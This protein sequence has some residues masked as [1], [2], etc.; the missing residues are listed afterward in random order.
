MPV[1]LFLLDSGIDSSYGSI[2]ER[3]IKM[4]SGSEFAGFLEVSALSF[5]TDVE[6]RI[7]TKHDN[8]MYNIHSKFSFRSSTTTTPV[9]ILY[10]LYYLDD[11]EKPGH[12]S[13]LVPTNHFPLSQNSRIEELASN[14][15]PTVHI[16][17]DYTEKLLSL[18]SCA[19][20]QTVQLGPQSSSDSRHDC[21]TKKS[22][23]CR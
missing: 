7:F 15:K 10:L 19:S 5:L 11:R 1:Y 8:D 13:L 9:S 23:T 12:F 4:A 17:N 2:N 20:V 3:L 14:A 22:S 16:D 18:F 21:N 6:I